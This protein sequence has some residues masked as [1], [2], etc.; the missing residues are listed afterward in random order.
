MEVESWRLL[1]DLASLAAVLISMS[2]GYYA[3]RV[4]RR[5]LRRE[6][7]DEKVRRAHQR[8]DAVKD[9]NADI[10]DRISRTEKH[11][12]DV[13]SANAVHE[14]ALSISNLQG[15][16]KSIATRLDGM[17]E[18]VDRQEKV[19]TRLETYVRE[20]DKQVKG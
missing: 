3:W 8:I 16:M 14:L 6:E 7:V 9:S 17:R 12:E 4:S 20:L 5:Q 19:A 1:V 2:A 13:P 15:E 11:L 18:L 10:R